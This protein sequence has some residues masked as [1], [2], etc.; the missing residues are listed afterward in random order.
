LRT[1]LVG[2]FWVGQL[3]VYTRWKSSYRGRPGNEFFG[4]Y[5][6]A[7]HHL[8]GVGPFNYIRSVT[9]ARETRFLIVPPPLAAMTWAQDR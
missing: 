3:H 9:A 2:R 8:E 5:V 6:C 7:D 1:G 4:F